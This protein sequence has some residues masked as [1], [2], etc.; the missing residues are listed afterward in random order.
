MQNI[1]DRF[2]LYARYF[3][4]KTVPY[5]PDQHL[6]LRVDPG[7]FKKLIRPG[8]RP[9]CPFNPDAACPEIQL[10]VMKGAA[11]RCIILALP[12]LIIRPQ[13]CYNHPSRNT[14]PPRILC[15]F[16]LLAPR[17]SIHIRIQAGNFPGGLRS[18]QI[19]SPRFGKMMV[20]RPPCEIDR[21]KDL[22]FWG[23][24]NRFEMMYRA[25]VPDRAGHRIRLCIRE[26]RHVREHKN[27]REG[28]TTHPDRNR[29]GGN[30]SIR[31]RQVSGTQP[32]RYRGRQ[33]TDTPDALTH[34]PPHR[35]IWNPFAGKMHT[36]PAACF[37]VVVFTGPPPV[38]TADHVDAGWPVARRR[39][40][41][42]SLAQLV[43]ALR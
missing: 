32:S 29:S 28:I 4:S 8:D 41:R 16:G 40:F 23:H 42:G 12:D 21:R 35:Y 10:H 27:K 11:T 43:R 36:F 33:E 37:S 25:A 7:N 24:R 14:K 26:C 34:K 22:L 9:G 5:Q 17:L 2:A 39:N 20:R 18:D 31:I 19:K 38:R 30:R 13:T 15:G 6:P 3:R 1:P